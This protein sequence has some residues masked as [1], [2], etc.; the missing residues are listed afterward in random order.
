M[1][2]VKHRRARVVM[3]LA[4]IGVL[5]GIAFMLAGRGTVVTVVGAQAPGGPGRGLAPATAPGAAANQGHNLTRPDLPNPF[6]IVENIGE[7]EGHVI[8][9]ELK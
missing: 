4:L 8:S 2:Q 1:P 3:K 9:V 5:V 6:H 7:T